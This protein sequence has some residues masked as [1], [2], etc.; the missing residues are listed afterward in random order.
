MRK[1]F[2]TALLAMLGASAFAQTS[3]GTVSV[4][5]S[6]GF[7]N[8]NRNE[9]NVDYRDLHSSRSINLN[10]S[11][12]YFLN[13]GLELG[14]GLGLEHNAYRYKWDEGESY[15]RYNSISL[16]PYARKYVAITEQLQLHGTGFVS[17]GLGNQKSG[18]NGDSS[19]EV[20]SKST[21]LG[22]GIYP[23][24]TYFVTPKLGFTARFG[25]LSFTR[26]RNKPGEGAY[27]PTPTTYNT[28]NADLSPTSVGIGIGYFI[29]R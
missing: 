4:Q 22:I 23:G 11:V 5:G 6:V 12:G 18:S 14:A 27:N 16:R 10:P 28:F 24:L 20:I 15:S 13:A 21:T 9:T 29:A 2:T 26:L 17:L 19:S 1:I 7:R 25:S 8:E 3:Q